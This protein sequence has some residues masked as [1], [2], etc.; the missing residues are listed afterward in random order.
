MDGSGRYARFPLAVDRHSIE[1][2][3]SHLPDPEQLQDDSHWHL[4]RMQIDEAIGRIAVGVRDKHIRHISLFALARIPLLVYLGY[5][6]DDKVPVELFQKHRGEEEGWVWPEDEPAAAFQIKQLR[7]GKCETG[8]AV[9]L[10]LSGTLTLADLPSEIDGLSVFEIRPVA[11]VPN[12]NLFR[13]RATLDAFIRTYQDL[14]ATLEQSHKAAPVIHLFPAVPVTA[15]V[16]CGRHL[17]RH[18]HPVL[19]VY[20]RIGHEFRLVLKVNER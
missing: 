16:A 14:L 3:L 20:D 2:D 11:A 18:V 7:A 10:S 19:H 8:V 17:M 4:G 9:M 5:A 12:P 1:I 6:L 13:S 15:A